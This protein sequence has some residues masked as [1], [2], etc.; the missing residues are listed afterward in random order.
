[1]V[2]FAFSIGLCAAA[3]ESS[4]EKE[5]LAREFLDRFD[6]GL[7]AVSVLQSSVKNSHN[8]KRV[9]N[10]PTK[11]DRTKL[12]TIADVSVAARLWEGAS[13]FFSYELVEG[14]G[15]DRQ[16]GGLTGVNDN[17]KAYDDKFAEFWLEQ[18][19]FEGRVVVTLGKLD[20]GAYFDSNAVANDERSQFLSNQ[21]V[22]S[23]TIDMPDYGYGVRIGYVP[24]EWLSFN[25]G[26]VEDGHA[27]ANIAKDRFSI[28]EAA[29]MPQFLGREG[30]Y[31]V[32]VW[33]NS[34]D[35]EKFKNAAKDS[36]SGSGYGISFHQY[37]TDDACVFTRWGMQ[38]D[39]IYEIR[40]A[41]S[42]GF[43]VT[44]GPWNR[45]DDV[46]GLAYGRGGLSEDYRDTL[47]GDDIRTA[48]EGRM[49]AYY[50]FFINEHITISPDIQVVH[51]LTGASKANTVTIFGLRLHC[52]L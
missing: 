14:S 40:Q 11:H 46:F 15:L 1:M 35:H 4:G 21:F 20:P 33:H 23:P 8:Y 26:V 43:S 32:Y 36:E 34:T 6:F 19:L 5:G 24:F 28:A 45:P 17:A 2:V 31:R 22:N 37:L 47:R 9:P 29:F 52:A 41:W 39:D 44:G 48:D 30:A 38:D 10:Y 16:A 12:Q 25:A 18:I 7:E 42:A 50:S 13:G 51:N 49:E 27:W 3:E